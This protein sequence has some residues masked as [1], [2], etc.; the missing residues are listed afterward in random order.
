MPPSDSSLAIWLKTI[1][2]LLIW[3]QAC[4]W[5]LLLFC[6][7]ILQKGNQANH[8][9]LLTE[10]DWKCVIFFQTL[11]CRKHNHLLP[12]VSECLWIHH[13]RNSIKQGKYIVLYKSEV[14]NNFYFSDFQTFK[15]HV[16]ISIGEIFIYLTRTPRTNFTC[17]TCH[18]EYF[19]WWIFYDVLSRPKWNSYRQ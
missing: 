18:G 19:D 2:S 3:D 15:L 14:K 11:L 13:N 12:I 5:G 10:S 9:R 1:S 7:S 8:Q 4:T 6:A 16:K 17:P